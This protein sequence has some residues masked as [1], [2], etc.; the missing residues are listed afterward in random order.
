[1]SPHGADYLLHLPLV[2]HLSPEFRA[3]GEDLFQL[4]APPLVQFPVH[5]GRDQGLK[6]LPFPWIHQITPSS[7]A[8]SCFLAANSRDMTVP[9]GQPTTS[10]ISL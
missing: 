5:G 9:T 10:A 7:A 4:S 2:F 6:T 1:V 3:A 8:L